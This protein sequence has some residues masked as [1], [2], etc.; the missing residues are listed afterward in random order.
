MRAM[1]SVRQREEHLCLSGCQGVKGHKLSPTLF[2][3]ILNGRHLQLTSHSWS[4]LVMMVGQYRSADG[5]RGYMQ[6]GFFLFVAL[7]STSSS[8]I[9][10]IKTDMKWLY[11][12]LI[13]PLPT[14]YPLHT[15][16]LRILGDIWQTD[17][18]FTICQT[19]VYSS[20]H[21]CLSGRE[22]Q[23]FPI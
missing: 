1:L 19:L 18:I 3:S 2:S 15:S 9:L 13:F 17:S 23:H 11:P 14:F 7:C 20:F 8:V 21:K 6:V 16:M 12:S 4:V 22:V 10:Y 5:H